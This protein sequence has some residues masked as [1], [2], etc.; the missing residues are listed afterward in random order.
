MTHS[1]PPSQTPDRLALELRFVHAED[2]ED[3]VQEAWLAHLE[4]RDPAKAVSA[5]RHRLRRRRIREVVSS[6][7]VTGALS[8]ITCMH[9]GRAACA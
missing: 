7:L 1:F 2:R 9:G 8:S 4:G 6:D 5:F 3:A